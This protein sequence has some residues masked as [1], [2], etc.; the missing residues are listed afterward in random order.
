M[1][2]LRR[3]H[4]DHANSRI[5]FCLSWISVFAYHIIVPTRIFWPSFYCVVNFYNHLSHGLFTLISTCI[6]ESRTILSKIKYQTYFDPTFCAGFKLF[7]SSFFDH[8]HFLLAR[9]KLL[10]LIM[11]CPMVFFPNHKRLSIPHD[12]NLQCFISRSSRH[13]ITLCR[14]QKKVVLTISHIFS[15]DKLGMWWELNSIFKV[16]L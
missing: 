5:L 15:G 10:S 1:K 9:F 8:C 14:I 6:M 16:D 3:N 4:Y 13:K 12:N 7:Q 2:L 11:L